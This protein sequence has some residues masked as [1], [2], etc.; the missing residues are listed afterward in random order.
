MRNLA[1]NNE[2][3]VEGSPLP[4]QRSD[5]ISYNTEAFSRNIGLLTLADQNK[6]AST[7][8]AIAGM[9]GVG[10]V[11][12]IT[13]L[14]TGVCHFNIS[15]MDHYERVNMNR[16]YG[17]KAD[18]L[19]QPKVDVMHK[20]ALAVNPYAEINTFP[21]GIN[22]DNI[23][24]F[25]AGVDIVVDG[26]DAFNIK[27]RRLIFNTALA[28]GIPVIT[29]G[30]IGF[31]TALI[32][33]M[34]GKMSFDDYFDIRDDMDEDKQLLH[35]FIG[36]TPKF[37]QFNY[38]DMKED[39]IKTRSG[40]SLGLA[41]QLCS[42]VATTEVIRIIL[43]KKGIKAAPHYFQ[44]DL[45]LR[46][47]IK[48]Y[49]PWGNRN[50][51]QKLKLRIAQK[52]LANL[53]PVIGPDKVIPP[54]LTKPITG[55]IPDEIMLYLMKAG[56]QAPSGEN[57]Q[58]WL[59]NRNKNTIDVHLNPK[60]DPSLFNVK[61]I[62][63]AIACGAVIENIRIA[64]TRYQL[65]SDIT[66]EQF[67]GEN[68]HASITLRHSDITTSPLANF[69]WQ[70]QTNRTRFNRK[71]ILEAKLSALQ[72]I[73]EQAGASLDLFT[74]RSDIKKISKIV[75]RADVLRMEVRSIHELLKSHLHF[76]DHDALKARI[77]FP[78][79][80]LEAGWDGELFL[81]ITQSWKT[82]NFMNKLGMSHIAAAMVSKGVTQAS[83]MGL[84]RIKGKDMRAFFKGGQALENIWLEATR[85]GLSFQPMTIVT[86]L[87]MN[88][89]FDRTDVFSPRHQKILD[90]IWQDYQE[91]FN[92]DD[93]E[94]HIMLFRL[95]Y[96]KP[97]ATG[98]LR[99]KINLLKN[100]IKIQ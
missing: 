51:I 54:I 10:G 39:S 95:G 23:D 61:Q 37:A 47:F 26:M 2:G 13:L 97:M 20:E 43:D 44:Y 29:A 82:A 8:V 90:S 77:G 3:R 83:A 35:F 32:T 58:P 87:W 46:R 98:T 81:K 31:S 16:Q 49:M 12:L 7:R 80:N 30:P 52:R 50:P 85:L 34:P 5:L 42:A 65:S 70:R 22:E 4:S 86:F 6:L 96:G 25:L 36:L 79:K 59:L 75:L 99:K 45:L 15:D 11:H 55:D 24:V 41:C 84:I 66:V 68:L 94:T 72:Q 33:F 56:Q 48:S 92:C 71:L 67:Q 1:E 14:R 27:I 73:C 19:G 9:G 69:I 60:A 53:K 88:K 62:A 76:S 93:D 17:A 100:G 89:Q 40:P 78:I 57:T 21:N 91:T 18:T 63:S 28:K 64:A 74:E 38:S